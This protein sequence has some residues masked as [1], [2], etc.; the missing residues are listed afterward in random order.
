MIMVRYADDLV[1]VIEMHHGALVARL[2]QE[3]R[4]ALDKASAGVGNGQL[5]DLEAGRNA[6]QPDLSSLA[7]ILVTA[8]VNARWP[9]DFIH[10]QIAFGRR[11][12]LNIY[13]RGNFKVTVHQANFSVRWRFRR[14]AGCPLRTWRTGAVRRHDVL[15]NTAARSNRAASRALSS[16]RI[17]VSNACVAGRDSKIS[18]APTPEVSA[19]SEMSVTSFSES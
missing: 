17:W 8:K 14:I 11:F 5:Y 3:I 15:D 13:L 10:D 9:L 1:V 6:D 2:R 12:H 7:P 19:S 4:D 16:S 18:F